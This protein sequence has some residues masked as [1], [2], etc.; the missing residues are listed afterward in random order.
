MN[1]ESIRK[2]RMENE[3]KN[4][5]KEENTGN[6]FNVSNERNSQKGR[7]IEQQRS[8]NGKQAGGPSGGRSRPVFRQCDRWCCIQK[9]KMMRKSGC[10]AQ[11][12]MKIKVF[13]KKE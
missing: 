4:C 2:K 6:D 10:D 13:K 7:Y 1:I 8:K 12:K 9:K 5:G 3:G 11:L